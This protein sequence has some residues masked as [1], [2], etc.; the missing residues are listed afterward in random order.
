MAKRI[1][2][3]TLRATP[4]IPQNTTKLDNGRIQKG[5]KN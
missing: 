1:H 3:S 4:L 5:A 2:T